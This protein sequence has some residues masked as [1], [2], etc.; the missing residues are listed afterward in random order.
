[1]QNQNQNQ[2]QNQNQNQNQTQN[3]NQGQM[4]KPLAD[5]ALESHPNVAKNTTLGWGTHRP[6]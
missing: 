4:Q 1:M 3:Q 6:K 2:M 5:A